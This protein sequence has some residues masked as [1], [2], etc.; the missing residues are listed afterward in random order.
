MGPDLT[1]VGA[2]RSLE[3]LIESV[4]WPNRQIREG[5]M[6]TRLTTKDGKTHMGYWLSEENGVVTLR[7]I[8]A[9]I[10]QKI[11][12]AEIVQKEDA[13]SGMPAGLTAALNRQELA[14]LIAYLSGLKKK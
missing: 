3:L 6:T 13:G 12:K 1:E 8:A 5:Y 14:D 4:L 11:A 9:P 10:E 2:G 7:N